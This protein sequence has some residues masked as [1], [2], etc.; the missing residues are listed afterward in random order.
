MDKGGGT[1]GYLVTTGDPIHPG[2][3]GVFVDVHVQPGAH[4]PGV[5]GFHGDAVKIGVAAPPAEGRANQAVI[6]TV[7]DLFDVPVARVTLVSGHRS[8]RKRLLVQ[9][10]DPD[11][12]RKAIGG[13]KP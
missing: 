9:G 10:L 11:R 7:A 2:R 5:V 4:R 8:R 3:E 13:L 6:E 1:V 12:A